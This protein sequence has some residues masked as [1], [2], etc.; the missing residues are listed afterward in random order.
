[1]AYLIKETSKLLSGYVHACGHTHPRWQ[2]TWAL[3]LAFSEH[4]HLIPRA[5]QRAFRG[6]RGLRQQTPV[7][8]RA[9][10]WWLLPMQDT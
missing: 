8:H 9:L 4:Q 2:V 3:Q 5:L 6:G 7:T 1:M 10:R